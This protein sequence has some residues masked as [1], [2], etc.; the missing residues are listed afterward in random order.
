MFWSFSISNWNQFVWLYLTIKET[1]LFLCNF[2]INSKSF[3]NFKLI[4]YFDVAFQVTK[5]IFYDSTKSIK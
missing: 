1:K 5:V 2:Q 3:S 4:V